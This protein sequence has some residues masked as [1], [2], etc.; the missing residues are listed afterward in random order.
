MR[1]RFNWPLWSGFVLSL[2][3]FATYFTV[4]AK[5]PSTRD[6][7]WPSLLLF[8]VALTLLV[9]GTGRAFATEP[10]SRAR[11]VIASIVTFLGATIF[12]FFC[13]AIF[14]A[15]KMLPKSEQAIA[16]GAKAPDFT[17]P[18]INDRAVSLSQLIAAPGTKG[19]ALIFYRG[20][21]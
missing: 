8:G 13:F 6:L 14:I 4:F 21:W 10:R 16:V 17:L 20:Y 19:V 18:D 3:A 12:V 11:R 1:N 15:T 9:I 5:Y 2:A 7:P